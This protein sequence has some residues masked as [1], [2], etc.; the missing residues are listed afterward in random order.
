MTPGATAVALAYGDGDA[1]PRVVARGR[2]ELAETIVRLAR[3]AGVEIREDAG[4]ARLLL[5]VP[6]DDRIPPALY[7]A[8]AEVLAWVFREEQRARRR[9]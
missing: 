7:V 4:L 3:E 6:L 9:R 8:V 2:G 5:A 1:A